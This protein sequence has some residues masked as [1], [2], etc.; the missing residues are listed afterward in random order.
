MDAI[1]IALI[2]LGVVLLCGTLIFARRSAPGERDKDAARQNEPDDDGL[3]GSHTLRRGRR[4]HSDIEADPDV[5]QQNE[6][7]PQGMAMRAIITPPPFSAADRRQE[8]AVFQC[9]CFVSRAGSAMM[10]FPASRKVRSA[11]PLPSS[12]GSSNC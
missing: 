5:R 4:A 2:V 3:P 9:S 8:M 10:W 11:L 6:S 7:N 12:I 1:G